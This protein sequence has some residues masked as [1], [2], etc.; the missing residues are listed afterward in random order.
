MK[1]LQFAVALLISGRAR[2][3]W[4]FFQHSQTLAIRRHV[5]LWRQCRRD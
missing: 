1:A 4:I 3:A 2:A 5:D